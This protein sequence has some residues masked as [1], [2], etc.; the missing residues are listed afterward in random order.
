MSRE[1]SWHKSSELVSKFIQHVVDR[2]PLGG[3]FLCLAVIRR[4]HPNRNGRMLE[5]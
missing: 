4:I 2:E 5:G 1:I 3:A